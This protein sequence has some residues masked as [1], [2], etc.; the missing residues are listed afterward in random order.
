MAKHVTPNKNVKKLD[1]LKDYIGDLSPEE[2]TRQETADEM[3]KTLKH[4][5]DEKNS[6]AHLYQADFNK[7]LQKR[8]EDKTRK[9]LLEK[10]F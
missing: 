10:F 3:Y 5:V 6:K 8:V 2:R 9:P 1:D 4:I 7:R